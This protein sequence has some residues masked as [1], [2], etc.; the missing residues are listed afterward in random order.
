[1]PGTL[2]GTCQAEG[3]GEVVKH[4]FRGAFFGELA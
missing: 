1:M 3:D 2:A 4:Y